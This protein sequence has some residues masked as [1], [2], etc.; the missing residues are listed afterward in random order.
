MSTEQTARTPSRRR[1]FGPVILIGLFALGAAGWFAVANRG[2]DANALDAPAA[3]PDP[4][5][6]L[7]DADV[8]TVSMA[9]LNRALPV[10]GSLS[11]LLQTTIKAQAPG[12]VLDVTVREGQAVHE[13]DVLVR[14]DTR[15]LRAEVES[16]EAA[17]EKA[18]ADLALAKLNRDNSAAMLKKH[19]ISQNAYD[20]AESTYQVNLANVKAAEAQLSQARIALDFATVS[21]PFDGTIAQRFVQPGEKVDVGTNLFT[22]VDLTHLELQAPA[23]DYEVPSVHVGQIARFSVGGFGDRKFEGRVERINPMTDVGSRSIMLYLAVANPDGVLKGG[24]FAQGELILDQSGP[25]RAIPISAVRTQAGLPF[26]FAIENNHVVRHSITLGIRSEEQH[27]VEVREGLDEG[28]V[29]VSANLDRLK[30]GSEVT[31]STAQGAG[32]ATT[33]AR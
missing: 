17:L 20:T 27:L 12:E 26:V 29:V 25:V 8:A 33:T 11:P 24:M 2:N 4:V 9:T 22:L 30:E 6:E 10:T 23:P 7:A 1:R 19:F 28:A 31:V 21:A 14:I 13:G 5:F 18:R 3:E 16:R 15:N 32:V